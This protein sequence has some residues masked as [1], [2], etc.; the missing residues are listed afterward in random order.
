MSRATVSIAYDRIADVLIAQHDVAGALK[1]YGDRLAI[2]EQLAKTDPHN[3]EWQRDLAVSYLNM[4]DIETQQGHLPDALKSYREAIRHLGR[5]RTVR[6]NDQGLRRDLAV[7]N[8]K[9][10]D[11]LERQGDMAEAREAY[12][13]AVAIM[14]PLAAAD[15]SNANWQQESPRLCQSQRSR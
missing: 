6:F 9:A 5:L 12:R 2:R 3:P 7:A 13:Q 14:E 15:R 4:G 10:G 8:S 11:L 1:A